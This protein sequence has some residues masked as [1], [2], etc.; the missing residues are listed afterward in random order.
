M[1]FDKLTLLFEAAL[2]FIFLWS[3]LLAGLGFS[4]YYVIFLDHAKMLRLENLIFKGWDLG[5]SDKTV[6]TLYK[7]EKLLWIIER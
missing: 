4:I 3:M 5:T 1:N 7:N 2:C 6:C